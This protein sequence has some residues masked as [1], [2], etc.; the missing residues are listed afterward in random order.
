MLGNMKELYLQELRSNGLGIGLTEESPASEIEDA[1]FS[2]KKYTDEDKIYAIISVY[3]NEEDEVMTDY[4]F[5]LTSEKAEFIK[6][7]E[8]SRLEGLV[9]YDEV[10][11]ILNITITKMN[12]GTF[13][14]LASCRQYE[15]LF[16]VILEAPK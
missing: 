13:K 16:G 7:K 12:Y 3:K 14:S 8:E 5:A 1:Y 15:D 10:S 6:E 9:D 2:M 4:N 11:E